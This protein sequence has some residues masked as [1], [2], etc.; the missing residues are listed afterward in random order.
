MCGEQGGAWAYRRELG[1]GVVVEGDARVVAVVLMRV[2]VV[3]EQRPH[4]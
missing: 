1:D 4:L 2:G 3:D